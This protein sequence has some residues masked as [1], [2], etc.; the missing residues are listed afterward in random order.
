MIKLQNVIEVIESFAPLAFQEK[1]D[2]SGLLVGNKQQEITGILICI[3]VTLP[4]IEEAIEQNC[5]LIVSHHP[6]IFTGLKKLIGQTEVERCVAKAIKNDIALYAAHTNLDNANDGVSFRMAQKIGLQN[7]L[8][9][10]PKTDI[11]SKL[12]TFV[13]INFINKVQKAM[14]KAGAGNIGN[15]DCCS[16]SH[17]GKG[18]F[19]ASDKCHPFCGNIGEL[20]TED[21]MRLEVIFPKYLTS[22]IVKELLEAHPYEEPAFDI[23]PLENTWAQVGSGI[24]GNLHSPMNESDFLALLKEKFQVSSIKHS[25]LLNR[26][27]SKVAVCGGSGADFIGN[28]KCADAD[29]FVTA[30]ITYHRFSE[31]ENSII[32]ADIGHFESEQYTK[33]IIL[34]Q[35]IKKIPNFAIRL[36]AHDGHSVFY[37]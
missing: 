13:P 35:L 24:V 26:P 28:A 4:V 33:E 1:Y 10:V 18:T 16:F 23:I 8:V 11:L 9:L 30:D 22:K 7:T 36:S 6:I 20:H 21:E 2:N 29:I 5:N 34:E 12:V 19:R 37:S 3:D 25:K 31:A 15:Y 32:I 14:F 27:I 17:I